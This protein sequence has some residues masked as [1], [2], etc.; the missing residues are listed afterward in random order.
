MGTY[1][2]A[3]LSSA[4]FF[5]NFQVSHHLD[6]HLGIVMLIPIPLVSYTLLS[7]LLVVHCIRGLVDWF[8]VGY[9]FHRGDG[10]LLTD[11]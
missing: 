11:V 1:D 2:L 4:V 7:N 8:C 3:F 6:L 10:T 5:P 9:L